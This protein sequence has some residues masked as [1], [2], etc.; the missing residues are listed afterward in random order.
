MARAPAR[1]RAPAPGG[2]RGLAATRLGGLAATP[3][4]GLALCFTAHVQLPLGEQ[5]AWTPAAHP[6]R[7]PLRGNHVLLRPVDPDADAQ[8][9]YEISHAPHGD[10]L[11]WTYLPDGPYDSPE[12]LREMLR[13]AASAPEAAYF[14]LAPLPEERPL[15]LAAF[16]NV[17]PEHGVIEIGHVWFGA[18]LKRTTAATE[19]IYL[20]ARHAFDELR[21]RRLEWKC[22]SLNA[23][24]RSAAERFGFS[25]EGVFRN[26]LVV[27]GRN[28]DTAWYSIT[29][30][31]WPARRRAFEAWLAPENFDA[32]GRQV[33]RLA[34]LMH[35]ER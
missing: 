20:L 2:R 22:N 34:Q 1:L 6:Q 26:H 10:P 23:A 16:L 19:A 24:S 5:L 12:Q 3:L 35:A 13:W 18:A 29:D 15:G 11:I 7:E 33:R 21:Y 4:G 9:L 28:R 25:F 27:K 32:S 8:P 30:G 31:E 17:Q 14:T